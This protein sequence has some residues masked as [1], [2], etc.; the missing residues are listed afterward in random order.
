MRENTKKVIATICMGAV[1]L[2]SMPAVSYAE[3]A[4]G[5]IKQT[6][7]EIMPR[8]QYIVD[9]YCNLNITNGVASVESWVLGDSVD[10]TKAKVIA[11]LQVKGSGGW[12]PV[13]IWTDTQN[14]YRASVEE[15]K[16]VTKGNTYR[17]KATVTVW[18]G[19]KSETQYVY[20]GEEKA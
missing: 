4:V 2:T 20:S 3:T 1:A 6:E 7:A 11:E 16:S 15:S 5:S 17:V 14:D 9:A 18:E 19:S 8:M 10:A 13:A 12:T